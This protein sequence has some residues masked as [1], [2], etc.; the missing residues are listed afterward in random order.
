MNKISLRLLIVSLLAAP[1]CQTTR[2]AA[3]SDELGLDEAV[4]GITDPRLSDLVA[5]YWKW[6]LESRPVFAT[7]IGVHRY[8]DRIDDNSAAGI[9]RYRQGLASWIKEANMIAPETLSAPGDHTTPTRSL[10]TSNMAKIHSTPARC[11]P[12]SPQTNQACVRNVTW[13]SKK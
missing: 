8:D 5:R 9:E 13:H 12:M 6:Q 11:I 2:S 7:T 3:P 10:I 4:I 1:S